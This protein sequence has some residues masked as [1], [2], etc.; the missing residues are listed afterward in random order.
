LTAGAS[1]RLPFPRVVDPIAR[2]P[3]VQRCGPDAIEQV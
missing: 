3:R 1:D 2:T